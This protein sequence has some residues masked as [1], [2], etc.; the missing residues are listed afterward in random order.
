MK[1]IFRLF[2]IRRRTSSP[3]PTDKILF[4]ERRPDHE[5]KKLEESKEFL[6]NYLSSSG[7]TLSLLGNINFGLELYYTTITYFVASRISARS[8]TRN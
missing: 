6:L 3:L 4:E 8:D 7:M 1:V 5:R 2:V